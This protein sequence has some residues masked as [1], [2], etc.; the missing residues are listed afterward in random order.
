MPYVI[1]HVHL[2]EHIAGVKHALDGVLLAIADLGDRLGRDDD[3]G[4]LVL[5]T[6]G[7]NARFEGFFYLTLEARIGVD[8]VPLHIR[9]ARDVRWLR[10]G[11]CAVLSLGGILLCLFHL[12]LWAHASQRPVSFI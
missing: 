1:I 12:H 8:D 11:G 2:H 6:E 4:D 7:L 3:L 5:Q 10:R 9:I